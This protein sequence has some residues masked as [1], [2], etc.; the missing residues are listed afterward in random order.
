MRTSNYFTSCSKVLSHETFLSPNSPP[1]PQTK[2]VGWS[3]VSQPYC[4]QERQAYVVVRGSVLQGHNLGGLGKHALVGVI[5]N[6]V[7]E[8][9]PYR[10]KGILGLSHRDH[11]QS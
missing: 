5:Y 10:D 11:S 1:Y 8:S 9:L 4:Y 6:K 3:K 7:H 2:G